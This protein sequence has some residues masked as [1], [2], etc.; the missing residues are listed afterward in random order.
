MALWGW[1]AVGGI[2]GACLRVG[3]AQAAAK[4]WPGSFPV[5]TFFVNVVGSF[6]IG[7][8]YAV[9][10]ERGGLSPTAYTALVGGFLG[11]FTTFS[12]FSLEILRLLESGQTA[13]VLGYAVG[14]V[15]AGVAAVWLGLLL[16]RAG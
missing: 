14:S 1:V 3:L 15:V 6:L 16:G 13:L 11:S 5:A 9:G 2:V 4:W 10:L 12:S 7:L 8:L